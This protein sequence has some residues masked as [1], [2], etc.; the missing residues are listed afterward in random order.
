MDTAKAS[1][2]LFTN[3]LNDGWSVSGI[4]ENLSD[5][6]LALNFVGGAH[7]SD[8]SIVGPSSQ[9]TDD[10]KEG[11]EEIR[12]ILKRWIAEV[13]EESINKADT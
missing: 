4:R 7:H 12:R 8:L 5:D 3:G 1:R 13:K 10:V 6:I 2:I 11:F 9:D